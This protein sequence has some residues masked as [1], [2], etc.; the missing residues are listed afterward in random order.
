M[1]RYRFITFVFTPEMGAR[2]RELRKRRGL[3]LRQMALLMD[4]HKPGSFNLPARL[5]RGEVR[6]PSLGLVSDY[7]R[8]CGA[9]FGDITGIL[10][11]YT[12]QRPVL[13][14]KGDAEV[15]ELLKS[16]PAPQQRA[17]LRW[18]QASVRSR[19]E[20]AGPEKK[21]K[22]ET[23]RQRIFRIVWAFIHADWNEVFEEKLH[24]AMVRLG[25]TVPRSERKQACGHARRMFGILTR[26]YA[27]ERR[28]E[29]ALARAEQK[30]RDD[31]FGP[32]VVAALRQAGADAHAEL[33]RTGRLEWEPTPEQIIAARGRPPK[34]E[35]A[36][37][38]LELDELEPFAV[39]NKEI[40][41]VRTMVAAAVSTWMEQQR[42]DYN[43]SRMYRSL[44]ERLVYTAVEHGWGSARWHAE[45]ERDVPKMHDRAFGEKVL[46]VATEAFAVW[47]VRIPPRPAERRC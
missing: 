30:A 37:T 19:A 45:V 41:L 1:K 8:A 24:E 47:K 11:S 29:R 6:Q 3:S 22:V 46:G 13:S 44:V 34:V 7:L 27:T 12:R 4:R 16:L 10:D 39:R 25:K 31:G 9:R 36:E 21:P 42:L 20:P 28:R 26:H 40:G 23:P 5:E 32:Q 2:L 35:R 14:E 43:T 18:E 38:R 17:M 15:A 33:L